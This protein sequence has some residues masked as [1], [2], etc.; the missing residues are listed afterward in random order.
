[1]CRCVTDNDIQGS[2]STCF[3]MIILVCGR[4][5]MRATTAAQS[6]GV[7]LIICDQLE[8]I[9][10]HIVIHQYHRCSRDILIGPMWASINGR[11]L[12]AIEAKC[13]VVAANKAV[14]QGARFVC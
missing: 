5:I 8:I 11:I 2:S 14:K 6:G 10:E 1:M 7:C 3:M 12:N 9:P 13:V 4:I